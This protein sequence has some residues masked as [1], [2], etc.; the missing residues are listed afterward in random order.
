MH[1]HQVPAGAGVVAGLV[2]LARPGPALD[3]LAPGFPR[4]RRWVVR[5]LG[6]RLVAQHAAVL[7]AARPGVVRAA[8]AVDVVHAATMLPLV[9]SPR[10]GRAARISAA[11]AATYAVGAYGVAGAVPSRA[12]SRPRCGWTRT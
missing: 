12:W 3:R 10:Y 11:V 8:A 7:V 1:A 6:A 4:E 5:L 9:R 2:L